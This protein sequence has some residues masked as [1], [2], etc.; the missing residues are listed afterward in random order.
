MHMLL[1]GDPLS[2]A[3]AAQL[4]L[5][6]KAVPAA[7]LDAA[8]QRLTAQ[9]AGAA[10]PTVRL[11]KKAFYRQAEMPD[12]RDAYAL[13]TEVMVDNM[14]QPDAQEGIAAFVEKR[15]PTWTA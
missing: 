12:V 1:S 14:Q 2:A 4:G 5:I 3:E 7:N 15:A 13:G 10:T 11:G 9:I 6:S 8:V